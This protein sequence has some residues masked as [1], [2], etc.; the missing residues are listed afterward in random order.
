MPHLKGLSSLLGQGSQ[1]VPQVT[2]ALT[3]LVHSSHIMI[4]QLTGGE[5]HSCNKLDTS[6]KTKNRIIQLNMD[7]E[8]HNK[9][10]RSLSVLTKLLK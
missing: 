1:L 2:D 6:F 4:I 7:T 5:N 10:T 9:C 8:L 3:A